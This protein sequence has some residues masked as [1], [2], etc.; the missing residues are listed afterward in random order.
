MH[1]IRKLV[2]LICAALSL[3]TTPSL[4]AA[5]DGKQLAGHVLPQ[6]VTIRLYD[7]GAGE[8][9]L[10]SGFR[11]GNGE[12]VTNAHVVA[13]AAWAEISTVDGD[14]IGVAAYA[15]LLDTENDLAV[16]RVPGDSSA[17]LMLSAY[18]AEIGTD[19]WAFGA[20]LGLEGTVSTG[21]VAAMRTVDERRLMQITAPI[22]PGSSGGPVVDGSGMVVGVVTSMLTE[23]QNLN[24]AVP[25]SRLRD[26]LRQDRG[27]IVFP[28]DMEADEL[29]DNAAGVVFG[30]A[31]ADT[32]TLGHS[33]RGALELGDADVDGPTDFF[34]FW[35][36]EGQRVDVRVDSDDFD[37]VVGMI[38]TCQYAWAE[39]AWF[40]SN[41]DDGENTDSR[42]QE[43]LPSTGLYH[44]WVGSYDDR[45]GRYRLVF[46]EQ[47][48]QPQDTDSRWRYVGQYG[49]GEA[50][51]DSRTISRQRTY[52]DVWVRQEYAE[53]QKD[54]YY[55]DYDVRMSRWRVDCEG[56]VMAIAWNLNLRG[57]SVMSREV[58]S[59][60]REWKTT[61]PSSLG[62]AVV[63]LLCT[64]R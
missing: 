39:D 8:S 38:A 40:V 18:D 48:E 1:R 53:L 57:E 56:R 28:E 22:S 26:L 25:V 15:V 9:G 19:I 42:M 36:E 58:A 37:T 12:I 2:I 62:E 10:G 35:G 41:D 5:Y 51:I 47:R 45:Y 23:G 63:E 61:I 64:D 16:L 4:A 20:P 59:Y 50:Y 14:L 13:G 21:N 24:F 27:R 31:N 6:V 32:I 29:D 30:M 52:T 49:D 43:T 11:I 44:L 33:Y 17:G 46:D 55:G 7:A 60:D 34:V 54:D 3:L